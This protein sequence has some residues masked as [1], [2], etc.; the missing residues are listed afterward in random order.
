MQRFVDAAKEQEEIAR[1]AAEQSSTRALNARL[2]EAV[3]Q[4]RKLLEHAESELAALAKDDDAQLA[5]QTKAQAVAEEVGA[6]T[7]AHGAKTEQ[8]A[9]AAEKAIAAVEQRMAELRPRW[10]RRWRRRRRRRWRSSRRR[11]RRWRRWSSCRRSG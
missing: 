2:E 10:T 3:T 4:Q 7:D 8:V 11:R 1:K 6:E 9:K 5:R